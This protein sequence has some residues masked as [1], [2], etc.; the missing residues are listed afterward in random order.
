MIFVSMSAVDIADHFNQLQS[1]SYCR[2]GFT[3]VQGGQPEPCSPNLCLQQ[4]YAIVKP[5]NSYTG[6]VFWRVGVVDSVVLACV[7]RATTKK[8]LSTFCLAP[9]PRRYFILE[10]PLSYC[11]QF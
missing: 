2:H 4:Q 11:L 10:Q 8:R 6:G 7:L 1:I 3:L 5:A 9:P